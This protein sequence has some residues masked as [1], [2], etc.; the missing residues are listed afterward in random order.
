MAFTLA[1]K[2]VP[3][4]ISQ[5]QMCTRVH[6]PYCCCISYGWLYEEL[7]VN[8]ALFR[9]TRCKWFRQ[10]WSSCVGRWDWVCFVQLHFLSHVTVPGLVVHHDD[11][12]SLVQVGIC[13]ASRAALFCTVV[14]LLRVLCCTA[15]RNNRHLKLDY[16][17]MAV[18]YSILLESCS[19]LIIIVLYYIMV[20]N[21]QTMY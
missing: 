7:D 16:Y 5:H 20:H 10:A 21:W 11:I 2:T 4:K 6:S 19:V 8:G 12:D 13:S 18:N 14:V 15:D 9:W 3:D 17:T 1:T